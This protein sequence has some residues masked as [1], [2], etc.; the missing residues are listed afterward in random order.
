M[1]GESWACDEHGLRGWAGWGLWALAGAIT[2]V[3]PSETLRALTQ[4]KTAGNRGSRCQAGLG[5]SVV[6]YRE[7]G[8]RTGRRCA[9]STSLGSGDV[10]ANTEAA[11]SN[12][13][14]QESTDFALSNRVRPVTP[15]CQGLWGRIS[16]TFLMSLLLRI[17]MSVA[18]QAIH[19]T[20][21]RRCLR[22]SCNVP[23]ACKTCGRYGGVQPTWRWSASRPP[24]AS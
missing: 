3:L 6:P 13:V 5:L 2:M 1:L 11:H 22:H 17:M 8:R 12:S 14:P 23:S 9:W 16:G 19:Q 20:E 7:R 10:F 21:T 18:Y 15:R 4:S 24:L